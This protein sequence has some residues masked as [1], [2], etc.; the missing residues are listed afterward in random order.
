MKY[1]VFVDNVNNS[2]HYEWQKGKWDE[3]SFWKKD[4]IYLDDNVMWQ[5]D[6]FEESLIKACPKFDPFGET[7]ITEE[8]WNEI[9]KL[10]Y[11][12][13]DISIEIYEEANKWLKDEEVFKKYGCFTI[14]GI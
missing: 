14:L 12:R 1:F 10:V 2:W 6:G 4:S 9:G 3:K 8:I 7:E 5:N 13:D 11:K